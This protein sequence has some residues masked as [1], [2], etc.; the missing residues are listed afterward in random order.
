MV[1]ILFVF[2]G[3][4]VLCNLQFSPGHERVKAQAVHGRCHMCAIYRLTVW[5]MKD[6]T[7][8]VVAERHTIWEN[9]HLLCYV[10]LLYQIAFHIL[11]YNIKEELPTKQNDLISAIPPPIGTQFAADAPSN[12][13]A[14]VINVQVHSMPLCVHTHE[15]PF[16]PMT[17]IKKNLCFIHS[18]VSGEW[19]HTIFMGYR[20]F[21]TFRKISVWP[22]MVA[23]MV[24][25]VHCPVV[26][27]YFTLLEIVCGQ[28]N[29]FL[30]RNLMVVLFSVSV[31][32]TDQ[33]SHQIFRA[34]G[35]YL[36]S[37]FRINL[38]WAGWT[39]FDGVLSPLTARSHSLA[40]QFVH[41]YF[42]FSVV[43]SVPTGHDDRPNIFSLLR[44][45]TSANVF[46]S[47]LSV[48]NDFSS[49][50]VVVTSIPFGSGGFFRSWFF[51]CPQIGYKMS[52]HRYLCEHIPLFHRGLCLM[53]SMY[54]VQRAAT[55]NCRGGRWSAETKTATTIAMVYAGIFE[56]ESFFLVI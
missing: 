10:C 30:C 52:A 24:H 45:I 11:L 18:V 22:P 17:S 33:I 25:S 9:D 53:C 51:S 31:S 43:F 12:S 32:M 35:V 46:P 42:Y 27:V 5:T 36:L 56:A 38:T 26:R 47:L 6:N 54:V 14:V 48:D 15:T 21:K 41:I 7:V 16:E 29:V 50:R 3:Q 2:A 40:P 49:V 39:C 1:L 34:R 37:T 4:N 23:H 55:L 44:C 8:C 19:W 28:L 20:W 13:T